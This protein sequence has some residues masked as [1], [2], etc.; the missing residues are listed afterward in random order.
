M[1][2]VT[3]MVWALRMGYKGLVQNFGYKIRRQPYAF[4]CFPA[5]PNSVN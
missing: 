3:V 5:F 1:V 4:W 2:S